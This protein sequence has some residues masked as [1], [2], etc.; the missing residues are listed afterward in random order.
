MKDLAKFPT[1]RV[2]QNDATGHAR[3]EVPPKN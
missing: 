2:T 1:A 3:Q